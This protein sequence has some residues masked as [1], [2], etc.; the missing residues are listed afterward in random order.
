MNYKEV[1]LNALLD[2]YEK[3]KSY[4][5]DVNR[6][7][8]IKAENIKQYHVENYDDKIVFHNIVKE[9]KKKKLVDFSWIK[10]EEDNSLNEIWLI[11]ENI[12]VAYNEID[13]DNP[14]QAYQE[15]L[16][17]L[18]KTMFKEQWIVKFCDEMKEYMLKRQKEN[19]LLPKNKAKGILIALQ[20]IDNMQLSRDANNILKRTFSMK[21]YHDSK[22]FEKNIESILTK[23][24]K[25]YYINTDS[26]N[27]L[28]EISDND[29]LAQI[30]IV[31]YPEVIEF[32]GNMKCE[33]DGV[34]LT[35]SSKTKG[36][37]INAYTIQNMNHIELLNTR[38]IVF[39]ENKANYIDYIENKED[40][41][42]VIYHG[43]FYSPIKGKFFEKIYNASN[44]G[45]DKY[46]YYHWSDIDIG[47]FKIYARLRDNI[48]P[49]LLPYKMDKNT[50]IE[51]KIY[52][53]SFDDKY[54]ELLKKLKQENKYSIFFEVIDYMLENNI[55]LEQES[56]I[57]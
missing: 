49:E 10:Y 39:V 11:K 1:I 55:R 13:R 37:Y 30:G 45:K 43:G 31:K 14:K 5:N 23:I 57:L 3:S 2:K 19:P 46:I 35:F 33:I 29:V 36:S 52:W 25:R 20:E 42:F 28:E 6:R 44:E 48:I 21:C 50:L 53:N 40:D 12:D 32:C 34:K 22:Y 15:I 8:I 56:I 24:I 9:L 7:I 38:K 18:Q 26:E 27:I 4:L 47:G 41:E 54:R 51:N 16:L 17:Y